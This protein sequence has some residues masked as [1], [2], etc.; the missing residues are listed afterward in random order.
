LTNKAPL[1]IIF[2]G[3]PDFAA[4]ALQ[5]LID[6]GH[7]ICAVYC[8]PD[9]R[10]GRGKKL[11]A[12]PVK[13]LALEHSIPV[14]QPVN[15]KLEQAVEELASYQADL[16]V[17]VAYG[18]LL[19]KSVLETPRYGCINIHGSLLPRWRG[20]APIQR[21]I[22]SGDKET[23]IT[24][25]Q[26]DIGLDTGNMLLKKPCNIE[27]SET[28]SSLHDKLAEAGGCAIT[29]Y[30]EQFDPGKFELD[31]GEK[32]DNDL[33]NYAHKLSK[34]QAQIDWSESA[35]NIERKIRA[36]NAWPVSFTHVGDKRLR[37]WQ[38]KLGDCQSKH[39]TGSVISL[40]KKGIE[41]VCGDQQTLLLTQLQPDG[42]K[43]MDAAALLNSRRDWFE[44]NSLLGL[45][46]QNENA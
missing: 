16:M 19:P 1:K 2:A 28:G 7:E 46:S 29:E 41:V 42:S 8:Q 11:V 31:H 9:R 4:I 43:A 37:V 10:S 17:V 32:Q 5:A 33:A 36:F 35:V 34:E 26:M 18:L 30:L 6:A 13:Q 25:M 44:Q 22:E 39:L 12:G 15:F 3:T 27:D 40:S 20:A 14:E 23:G 21:A 45:A 24:I 38:A